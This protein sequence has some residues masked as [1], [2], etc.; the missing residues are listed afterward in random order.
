M[1]KASASKLHQAM[2]AEASPDSKCPICLDRFVNVAYLNHCL[3]KFCFHCIQ[4]WS[5][6]KAECPLCKQPFLS[7]FHTVRADDDFEEYVL[8]PSLPQ[9]TLPPPDNGIVFEDSAS[10]PVWQ[11]H[12]EIQEMIRRLALQRQASAEGRYT[13]QIQEEDMITFRRALYRTG[14]RVRSI[15][16]GGR[17]RDISAEFFRLNPACLYRLGP[18]LRR[19]LM[20]LFGAHSCLV[21]VMQHVI[22]SNLTRC[23]LESQV[24]ADRLKP[25][26]LNRTEHFLHEFV[27]FAR[28]P[29]NMEAYDLHANYDCPAPSYDEGSHSDS[30]NF[31]LSPDEAGSQRPGHG[32]AVTGTGQAPWDD[33]TPGPS[34]S[35]LGEIP[36]NIASPLETSESSDENSAAKRTEQQI[37][38]QANADPNDSD[39]SSSDNCIIIVYVNS[40]AER[41]PELAELSSDSAESIREEKRQDVKKQQPIRCRSWSDSDQ[42][43]SSPPRSPVCN[44]NAGSSR[45]C[46]SPSV[47]KRELNNEERSKGKAK[48]LSPRDSVWSPSSERDTTCSPCNHRW[49]IKRKS[50]SPQS[51]SENSRSSYGHGSGRERHGKRHAKRRRS[52]S[53]ES[54]KHRSKRSRRSSGTRDTSVCQK[55]QRGSLS[56]ESTASREISRSRSRSK[57]RG[58]RRSRS[59]DSDDCYGRD[60][61]QGR[62][63][64]GRALSSR[65]AAG[66]DDSCRRRTQ[67]SSHYSRRS[68]SPEYRMRSSTGKTDADSQKAL[69]ER[70]YYYHKRCRSRSRSSSRSRTPSGGAE[71]MK[72]EKPGGKRK[73]KTRHLESAESTSP[74]RENDCKKKFPTFSNFY[75]N[76]DSLSDSRSSSETKPKKKRKKM[77]SPS[78][79]I[80]YEGKVTDPTKQPKKKQKKHEKQHRK[81]HVPSSPLV[82][83]I[84]SDSGQEPENTECDSSVTWTG[85]ARLNARENESSSSLLGMTGR[86]NVYGVSKETGGACKKYSIPAKRRVFDGDIPT[87][88]AELQESADENPVVDT[89]S[90]STAHTEAV[91]SQGRG[92]QATPSTLLFSPR[93]SVLEYPGRPQSMLRLPKR[94]VSRSCW[95]ESPEK[96][97]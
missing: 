47:E 13:L 79:E 34:Y 86:E 88:G 1:P 29:F 46:L 19:E 65:K 82:I 74:E 15:Q 51:Y 16:D 62:Y 85:T 80:V 14:L 52:R 95:F 50:M 10:Q 91:I 12:A 24:F 20:V 97:M 38:L 48:R 96:N 81:R 22:L 6:S 84:D 71:R 59:R 87:A 58:S 11:S 7:I 93:L 63:H 33:E 27:T 72:N 73:Y 25:F 66:D 18:W 45:S 77:R 90:S 53:R 30:P 89:T 5:K 21:S 60:S 78:V 94:I 23:D 83:T 61:Y 41:T 39:S 40:P 57:G 43:R 4:E 92:A 17:Y 3:H 55:S 70:H 36:L 31:T 56:R 67:P 75:T 68:A 49:P 32:S 54:R 26:L 8:S 76:E 2:P 35:I 42:S 28:C 69:R 37:R 44:D 9:R 64:W